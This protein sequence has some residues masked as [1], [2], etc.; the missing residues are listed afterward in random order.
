MMNDEA[1]PTPERLGKAAR[2]ERRKAL[3]TT[4]NASPSPAS[5][6]EWFSR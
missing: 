5:S 2:N 6:P 3:A 1:S 4:L